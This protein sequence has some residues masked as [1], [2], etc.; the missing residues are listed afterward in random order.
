VRL[1]RCV[2]QFK[3][4]AELAIYPSKNAVF[5]LTVNEP[6]NRFHIRYLFRQAEKEFDIFSGP[7]L[8]LWATEKGA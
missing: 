2:D 1:V 7:A 4:D 8:W 3:P 6:F 5:L